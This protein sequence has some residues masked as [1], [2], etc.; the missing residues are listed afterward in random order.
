MITFN[1]LGRY[2]RLSNQMFQIASTIG[3]AVKNNL[4]FG[5]PLWINH[6]HK[7]SFGSSEDCDI[8]K[9]FKNPL[10]IVEAGKY[11]ELQIHW[12]YYDLKVPD[13]CSLSGHMQSEK[14]FEHCSDL[15][16]HYF[17][18]KDTCP[19][20][21]PG[22]NSIAIHVRRGDYDGNYHTKLDYDNYYIRAII[23]I[24]E[25]IT[26]S[27][28]NNNLAGHPQFYIFSDNIEECKKI[29]KKVPYELNYISGNHYM[30]DFAM[31]S[32]CNHHIIGNS[33]FSWWSAWLSKHTDKKVV[34]PKQWFGK[35]CGLETK[36]IYAKNWIVI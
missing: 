25:H 35:A 7:D 4:E 36:D 33:T 5:F 10:P 3:I 26:K 21:N 11:R 34:A 13:K 6:D 9:Y 15:I 27:I 16:R 12:G 29:F 14:Y 8:Y 32:K 19:E 1:N 17:E 31:M 23:E 30:K 24:I 22:E 2:G 20:F 18:L 28:L